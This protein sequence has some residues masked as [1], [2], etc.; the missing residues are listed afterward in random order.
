MK[1]LK[2]FW[3]ICLMIVI[4]AVLSGCATVT[5]NSFDAKQYGFAAP[6]TEAR[7]D[8]TFVLMP[9]NAPSISQGFR[10]VINE[11]LDIVGTAGTPVIAAAAGTVVYAFYESLYGNQ[12]MIEHGIDNNGKYVRSGYRHLEQLM[13]SKGDKVIRGQ[14]IGTIGSSGYFAGCFPY[15]NYEVLVVDNPDKGRFEKVNPHSF[16]EGGPG[17]V[18]CYDSSKKLPDS[19]FKATYPVP[20]RKLIPNK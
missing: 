18:T 6:D 19:P 10:P 3:A 11:G 2:L 15:L 7:A 20:C 12:I 13:V 1:F 4:S 14:Q 9:Q 16:W 5:E 8:G 17:V